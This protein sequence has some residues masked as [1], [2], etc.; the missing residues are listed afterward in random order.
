MASSAQRGAGSSLS[1]GGMTDTPGTRTGEY[2]RLGID[3][4]TLERQPVSIDL[5]RWISESGFPRCIRMPEPT[6]RSQTVAAAALNANVCAVA[7]FVICWFIADTSC[8]RSGRSSGNETRCPVLFPRGGSSKRE[9][10]KLGCWSS[11]RSDATPEGIPHGPQT[12]LVRRKECMGVN[13]SLRPGQTRKGSREI[14]R[15]GEIRKFVPLDTSE[16][17]PQT[18]FSKE[19]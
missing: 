17:R 1:T 16:N 15:F 8:D 7:V 19:N 9:T 13:T 11:A 18:C 6:T 12:H 14:R 5:E 3:S 10:E 4:R 2:L